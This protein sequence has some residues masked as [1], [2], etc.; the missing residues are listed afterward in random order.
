[1]TGHDCSHLHY[2]NWYSWPV[3]FVQCPAA[4]IINCN[5]YL[6]C[7]T[8]N[9]FIHSFIHSFTPLKLRQCGAIEIQL[10]LLLLLLWRWQWSVCMGAGVVSEQACQVAQEGTH[11]EESRS[12]CAQRSPAHLQRNS[13]STGRTVEARA[14]QTPPEAASTSRGRAHARRDK[15]IV[16]FLFFERVKRPTTGGLKSAVSKRTRL[17]G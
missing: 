4:V 3:T 15:P 7:L 16:G 14:R 5:F 12:S 9:T 17:R 1:M 10:L 2:N 13:H 8:L 11:P 6:N